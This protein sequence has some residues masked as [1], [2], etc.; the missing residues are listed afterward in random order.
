M[1]RLTAT[2]VGGERG[3]H[4]PP[5]RGP[6]THRLIFMQTEDYCI[7]ARALEHRTRKHRRKQSQFYIESCLRLA[8]AD[9]SLLR[10]NKH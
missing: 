10:V 3:A 4:A 6:V 7:N 8:H 1:S 5:T 9:T 2:R